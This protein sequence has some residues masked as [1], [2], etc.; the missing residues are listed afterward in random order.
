[1]AAYKLGDLVEVVADGYA[2]AKGK[3]AVVTGFDANGVCLTEFKLGQPT[4]QASLPRFT[5]RK[6]SIR[7]VE[8]MWNRL[9]H[10]E[11]MIMRA[12]R[13]WGVLELRAELTEVSGQA[14]KVKI[15]REGAS[16]GEPLVVRAGS[17]GEAFKMAFGLAYYARIGSREVVA[18]VEEV[19][20]ALGA[21]R[22]AIKAI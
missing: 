10:K 20:E 7:E 4:M 22:Q 11:E 6:H 9:K 21:L 17:A 5:L 15:M 18:C 16:E 12:F 13:R 2:L 3:V 8:V 14:L 1:M 19:R